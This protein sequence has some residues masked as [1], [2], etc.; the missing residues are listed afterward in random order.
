MMLNS[1]A[2]LVVLVAIGTFCGLVRAAAQMDASGLAPRLAINF[3]QRSLASNGAL[4]VDGQGTV[5]ADNFAVSSLGYALNVATLTVDGLAL[6]KS[7]N[8]WSGSLS[9]TS[10]SEVRSSLAVSIYA[11]VGSSGNETLWFLRYGQNGQ[12]VA[13][14]TRLENDQLCLSVEWAK[15]STKPIA[16]IFYEGVDTTAYHHYLLAFDYDKT[17]RLYVDGSE[18]HN[19]SGLTQSTDEAGTTDKNKRNPVDKSYSGIWLGAFSGNSYAGCQ[20]GTT[21]YEDVRVYAGENVPNA[22]GNSTAAIDADG[23]AALAA[24]FAE[25]GPDMEVKDAIWTAGGETESVGEVANWSSPCKLSNYTLKALFA[26]GGS[27]A[28]VDTDLNLAGLVFTNSSA[29]TVAADSADRTV[30]LAGDVKATTNATQTAGAFVFEP[31]LSLVSDVTVLVDDGANLTFAGGATS[32]TAQSLTMVGRKLG[33]LAR[34]YTTGGELT[35]VDYTALGSVTHTAGGGI[36][37]LKGVFGAETDSGT[38]TINYGNYRGGTDSPWVELGKTRFDGVT[39]HK[40]VTYDGG[41]SQSGNTGMDRAFV[42]CAGTTNVFKKLVT[43]IP[44]AIMTGERDSRM[45]LEKG[46]LC[47]NGL[48]TL[49]G[50]DGS[51]DNKTDAEHPCEWVLNGPVQN[52]SGSRPLSNEGG[53]STMFINATNNI[54]VYSFTVHNK[55]VFGVDNAFVANAKTNLELYV[56]SNKAVVDLGTTTQTVSRIASRRRYASDERVGSIVGRYPS[57]LVV[58]GGAKTAELAHIT[59]N[60]SGAWPLYYICTNCQQQISGWVSI[61]M[62]GSGYLNMAR[63]APLESYGDVTVSAGTL[64]FDPDTTWL[65]GTNVTVRGTGTLKLGGVTFGE[66]A[67]FFAEGNDW[68]ID[69]PEGTVQHCA[70]LTVDGVKLAGG[71]YGGADSP[72]DKKSLA[73]HFVG[74]GVLSVKSQ[75]LTLIFF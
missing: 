38:L 33:D 62:C 28:L 68:K 4:V 16:N 13:L 26:A 20:V 7:S 48:L 30:G 24:S 15:T 36:L 50:Q 74:N 35:L 53:Y 11:K 18:V 40:A 25:G 22:S 34:D 52:L 17:I 73:A 37:R 43:V 69:I 59:N 2:R 64:E 66:Q 63:N 14:V 54:A 55:L 19:A 60:Q 8:S 49:K 32:A 3:D 6:Y 57:A 71:R 27:R 39:V 42:G 72:A 9:G 61:E 44:T 21:L 23:V 46:L 5:T 51:S 45:V 41:G 12:G 70:A 56:C 47:N 67:N 29:F 10:G 31:K 65:N 75:G 1:C 58:N